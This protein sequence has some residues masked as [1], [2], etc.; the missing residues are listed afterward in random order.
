MVLRAGPGSADRSSDG[1]RDHSPSRTQSPRGSVH[2][3][4]EAG[5]ARFNPGSP[6]TALRDEAGHLRGHSGSPSREDSDREQDDGRPGRE[7]GKGKGKDK[8]KKKK[9][10]AKGPGG[11]G[12]KGYKGVMTPFK[13]WQQRQQRRAN[14]QKGG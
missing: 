4:Q 5:R 9:G 11:K 2:F 10:G 3:D 12:K 8:G 14:K 1:V 13:F 6:A 7:R